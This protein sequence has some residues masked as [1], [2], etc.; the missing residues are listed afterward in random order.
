MDIEKKIE[1]TKKK[2]E[3]SGKLPDPHCTLCWGKGYFRR[4]LDAERD[5]ELC[6][7]LRKS[8]KKEIAC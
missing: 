7:C 1:V 6:G 3:S 4:V 2:I 8:K 5:V